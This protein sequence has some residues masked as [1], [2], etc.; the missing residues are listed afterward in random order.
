[1][2]GDDA[3]TLD[4]VLLPGPG[5][6]GAD[7]LVMGGSSGIGLAT[8]RL[9]LA[10]GA[11]VTIGGRSPS[12]LES[13]AAELGDVRTV[14]VDAEDVEA[15]TRTLEEMEPQHA[16]LST[17]GPY[18]APGTEGPG[19][20]LADLDI[21]HA[22]SWSASRFSP[23]L[24]VA[25]WVARGAALESLTVVNALLPRRPG[26]GNPLAGIHLPGVLGLVEA[27]AVDI[28]PTRVNVVGP[29]PVMDSPLIARF[30]GEEGRQELHDRLISTNPTGR[31]VT[32]HDVA[33]HVLSLVADPI[34]TGSMRTVDAGEA[35]VR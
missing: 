2:M 28:A 20:S 14:A 15:F 10:L 3:K 21:P 35:L 22:L 4:S 23:T 8:A 6:A 25:R 34:V 12:R 31:V 5:L 33:R 32:L 7:I 29:T 27:L 26:R 16:V 19:Y 18:V 17:S 30:L 9:A 11:D 24:T 1:M 13:T